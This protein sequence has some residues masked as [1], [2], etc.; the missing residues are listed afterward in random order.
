MTAESQDQDLKTLLARS[1]VALKQTR[2]QLETAQRAANEPIAIIGMGCRLPP[3]L[4]GPQA[5]WELLLGRGDAIREVP[6][7]RWNADAWFDADP[8]KPGRMYSKTGGFLRD[9]EAF[10][11][12]FFGIS[13][14]EALWIDPQHRMLLETAWAALEHAR[15]PPDR[16]L[17][18]AT[19]VFVGITA[20]D[21]GERL[22]RTYG[23]ELE[24]Y[25][26]TG[27]SL[28]FAAGRLAYTLGLRGPTI[29]IDTACSSSLV[30][31]HLA[32]QSLRARECE[33]AL[34]A[35]VNALV[36]PTGHLV[37][38]KTRMQSPSGR[39]HTFDA[40]AD[41]IARGEGCGVVV[42]KRLAEALRDGDVIEAVILGSAVNQ[43]GASGG[44]TVPSGEAQRAVMRE[45]L[46]RAQVSPESIGYVEAH[47]TGTPLGDPIELGSLAAVY[48][49]ERAA[50]L[51]VGSIKTNLG[52]LESAAGI[53]GLIKAALAVQHGHIPAHLHLQNPTPHFDWAA[54]PLAVPG[55]AREWTGAPRR[56]AVSAFGGSG[57][58]SH[59]IL[60][61]PPR[62]PA[63]Q[64]APTSGPSLVVVS[65]RSQA[66]LAEA[67]Q[68]MASALEQSPLDEVAR[69]SA[70]TRAHHPLR[71]AVVAE[72]GAAAIEWLRGPGAAVAPGF[73]GAAPRRGGPRLAFVFSG[74][75]S[76][77]EGMGRGLL[78]WAPV[79]SAVVDRCDAAI[80]EVSGFSVRELLESGASL[81]DTARAQP[82]LFALQVALAEQLRAWGVTPSV[83]VGHSVGEL[84]AAC[85]AGVLAP[86]EGARLAA[87]RGRLMSG[88]VERGA[89]AQI[90]APASQ[91]SEW[92]AE[93]RGRLWLAA[94][95]GPA[96]SVIAG[97]EAELVAFCGALESRGVASRRLEVSHAFHSGLMDPI[98]DALE[99]VAGGLTHA[100]P[101]LPF[102]SCLEGRLVG[103][104]SWP[105]AWRRHAREPVAFA[106]GLSAAV[107]AGCDALVEIGPSPVLLA[108]AQDIPAAASLPQLAVLRRR[109]DAATHLAAAVAELYTRGC[110]L[111]WSAY[112]QGASSA[113]R[114]PT[115]PFQRERFW[116]AGEAPLPTGVARPAAPV[117]L[118]SSERVTS[119]EID[120]SL[121]SSLA[122]HRIY[123]RVVVPASFHL[124]QAW[125]AVTCEAP[126]Q[127]L[128]IEDAT[129]SSAVVLEPGDRRRVSYRWSARGDRGEASIESWPAADAHALAPAERHGALRLG[130]E[131]HDEVAAW[132]AELAA[133]SPQLEAEAFY[134]G[135]SRVGVGLGPSF[136]W[137]E[138]V[139][140][141][142]DRALAR[143]RPAREAER[144]ATPL[145]AGLLDSLFQLLGAAAGRAA[146]EQVHVPAH[147]ERLR[148][149]APY[150]GGASWGLAALR[151]ARDGV[152]TGDLVLYSDEGEALLEV[153]GLTV[154]A[155]PLALLSQG[156][157]AAAEQ[158]LYL[159]SWG[160]APSLGEEAPRG[161]WLVVGEGELA[162]ELS[163]RLSRGGAEVQ[164]CGREGWR[165][166]LTQPPAG[167]V[168]LSA[169]EADPGERSPATVAAEQVSELLE[170]VQ[171]VQRQAPPPRLVVVTEEGESIDALAHSALEGFLRS[172]AWEVPALDPALVQLGGAPRE[173]ALLE[174]IRAAGNPASGQR[175]WRQGRWQAP[176]LRANVERD[177]VPVPAGPHRLVPG[178]RGSLEE[179]R[180][181]PMRR[182]PPGPGQVELELEATGVNFRDVLNVLGLYPGDPGPLGGE[183]V[184]R[185]VAV[186]EPGP[187]AL[188]LGARV[189]ALFPQQG[190]FATHVTV[191]LEQV[192]AVP[193]ELPSTTA[194]A[195]AVAYVSA[196]H[197]LFELAHLTS[198]QTVL[199]HAAAGGVG[200]CAVELALRA[201]ARVLATAGSARKRAFLRR[202]GVAAVFDSRSPAFAA[203]VLRMTEGRGADV[204]LSSVTGEV[205]AA[206]VRALA[207]GGVFLELGKREL[208]SEE[209]RAA[210][211]KP[212]A[213][214]AY[215]ILELGQ[216]AP[217]H[218]RALVL[219]GLEEVAAG[220]LAAPPVRVFSHG[221]ARAALR[222][223]AQARHLGRV[224]VEG[225]ASE[226][227]APKLESGAAYVIT[228][229]LG[230]L[231]G[232]AAAYL[233]R[234]GARRL[235]LLGRHVAGPQAQAL[236]EELAGAG[237]Q[238]SCLQVDVGQRAELA[239]AL[240][241]VRRELG[242]VRGVLHA[243]G[244]VEDGVL[245]TLDRERVAR[246]LAGKA[247]GAWNLHL[248][249][250]RDAL[251]WFCLYGSLV[252]ALGAP[253]QAAYAAAN[254][255]LA[256]LVEL[257]RSEGLPASLF[258]W[259]P[260]ELGMAAA[261]AA[262]QQGRWRALGL[263]PLGEG[264]ALRA[265][266]LGLRGESARWL[267]A[268]MVPPAEPAKFEGLPPMVA[269]P[270]GALTPRSGP[271]SSAA[272]PP[273]DAT[274]SVEELARATL[275]RVL[276]LPRERVIELEQPLW[277]L[278]LDSLMAVELR[279]TLERLCGTQLPM[280]FFTEAPT[281]QG[282]IELLEVPAASSPEQPAVPLAPNQPAAPLPPARSSHELLAERARPLHDLLEQAR[283]A[284]VYHFEEPVVALDGQWVHTQ[285]GRKKLMFATYS[286]LGLLG[287][288]EIAEAAAA[289]VRQYG[290]GTHGV[291]LNGGTLDL[292]KRLER[293]IAEFLGRE[294]A[295]VFSSGFM[296]NHGAITALLEPGD[297]VIGDQ[298]NHASIVDGC[299]ASGAVFRV[300]PHADLAALEDLLRQAPVDALRLIIVDALF[301]LDG[302]LVDLPGVVELA[303]RYRAL[304]MVDEAHS[305]GALGERGR[306]IEDH[307]HLPGVIDVSMGT[308]SKVVP[309][310]GGYI[311]G[312][313][314]LIEL[315]RFKARS[316]L[317]SASMPPPVAA[318]ALAS[319]EV[320]EREG[321]ERR[322]KLWRN[323][324]RLLAGLRRIGYD[325]GLTTSAVVPVIVG[326]E[327]N[328]VALTHFCQERGLFA[329]PVMPP[330]VPVGTAR[331]R[332]NV[333]A[334]HTEQDVDRA[335]T[336]L[337]DAGRTLFP[338]LLRGAQ[339]AA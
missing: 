267:V 138:Q 271:A 239:A 179:A 274:Q 278:G 60:E 30:A 284:G 172:V 125:H 32:C 251:D 78:S 231:G 61:Q 11:A 264:E 74:Q 308:L 250:Q 91:V 147:L 245:G 117:E 55:E 195:F 17:G 259:G 313:R 180:Y 217:Q 90:S 329:M 166:A 35:G 198:G 49:A 220:R 337:E 293:R 311:A 177:A 214:H 38:C 280:G 276:G 68:R 273:R 100:A 206:S 45:A 93:Q 260:W 139:R 252:G 175:A 312:S 123:G 13:P 14:R 334:T 225:A 269:G 20:G 76:Q 16:L 112:H 4:E 291:R 152:V 294:D 285:G 201:G 79:V 184:G 158:L 208:L 319:F 320:L 332:L 88:L 188:A 168:V 83:V 333:M 301:S 31:V 148:A 6:P 209:Q 129:F 335:L 89:M 34:A 98:L 62:R 215:D 230:A 2:E 156:L 255:F 262:R 146:T 242:P 190:G 70:L 157:R 240:A 305:L 128:V 118:P 135:F 222:T 82:A 193:P 80:L 50:P 323:V 56:A 211:G 241:Q 339:G 54:H 120:G 238:V 223:L 36:S 27:N 256:G 145:P 221:H 28:N 155:A 300:Y 81:L 192:F 119:L 105:E 167:I 176:T 42:L 84:A 124:V 19:G 219:R 200:L 133:Q 115:Y 279:N 23:S 58:N 182:T 287:H 326:S 270:L 233:A 9:L 324:E 235:A 64:Q 114:L 202:K 321:V 232:R 295:L 130:A 59:L 203:E 110:E 15:V 205:L 77:Y 327:R 137:I 253:G 97:A 5:L 191:A 154:R 246:T 116:P 194:A 40:A 86:E 29:A 199:I 288:P 71:C 282:L 243:A 216:R 236:L 44:L 289:A 47:G 165:A 151:S 227:L 218:L 52:H 18:S 108:L 111:D 272:P 275:A 174:I 286:Y 298:W 189:L 249:T 131:V 41:G 254:S 204:V 234:H 297:W 187:G 104:R 96:R 24:P 307:Y 303:R 95:N 213:Y 141:D 53:A 66:A 258:D 338:E 39:C 290:T 142:G 72:E 162:Q 1:I 92:L 87:E 8:E 244:I 121:E 144:Q 336:I 12:A 302:D 183:C 51:W 283:V 281:L 140:V 43:D 318:A 296:T 94:D 314:A 196:Y 306:G 127:H 263:R 67:R 212:F 178:A 163:E 210:F 322:H 316:Y 268:A 122:D 65:A 266:G 237:V 181:E 171:V 169:T 69:A 7:S 101:Q 292:H 21:Y 160:E 317:F 325:T 3:D 265:L 331:L 57:T 247:E 102:V 99:R 46:R 229:G 228:G 310:C 315:L 107:A 134:A 22:V 173:E 136:R 207:P 309:A 37:T 164:G 277:E 126:S 106:A 48:G 26:L 159:E 197:G 186:G 132:P 257:R 85:V 113:L 304:L 109:G 248:E 261:V 10:D 153:R 63:A 149:L 73:V 185:V 328:A 226:G 330:A 161:R 25:F 103:Q 143:F 224:V 150:Q 170:L 75:G 299:R 33:L